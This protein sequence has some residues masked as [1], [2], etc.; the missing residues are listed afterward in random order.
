M[1]EPNDGQL[2]E[3]SEQAMNIMKKHF[4][5]AIEAAFAEIGASPD[6][7]Q[8]ANAERHLAMSA[9]FGALEMVIEK[10]VDLAFLRN[11]VVGRIQKAQMST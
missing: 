6:P 4:A 2:D 5:P 1:S 3:K 8:K 11:R 7:T 9:L 10:G